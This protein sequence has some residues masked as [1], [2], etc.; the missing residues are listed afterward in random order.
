MKTGTW[1]CLCHLASVHLTV[2]PCTSLHLSYLL[3]PGPSRS[4][5][6]LQAANILR[7]RVMGISVVSP[8]VW[9]GDKKGVCASGHQSW[10]WVLVLSSPAAY[11]TWLCS[12]ASSLRYCL[13]ALHPCEWQDLFR[14]WCDVESCLAHCWWHLPVSFIL[15]SWRLWVPPF[16][17]VL[18]N[19][20]ILRFVRPSCGG[21]S[22]QDL[23]TGV[24]NSDFFKCRLISCKAMLV[25][26]FFE[27]TL[28][29]TVWCSGF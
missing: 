17:P 14:P 15:S 25:H 10:L 28:P 6:T 29:A 3:S 9:R 13:P 5:L 26:R 18:K 1:L 12:W 22:F 24:Q 23:G 2:S 19:V 4:C 16:F 11:I 7:E 20:T 21:V 8:T 27:R